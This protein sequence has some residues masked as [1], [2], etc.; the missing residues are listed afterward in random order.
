M[1]RV[2]W[3]VFAEPIDDRA[4]LADC[5]V[6]AVLYINAYSVRSAW[7]LRFRG[8]DRIDEM[9]ESFYGSPDRWWFVGCGETVKKINLKEV[10]YEQMVS[11]GYVHTA[12]WLSKDIENMLITGRP[13]KWPLW[14]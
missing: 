9:P 5:P 12:L 3:R 1:F 7:K 8:K 4:L 13:P 6:A 2:F 14:E 11:A 10:T